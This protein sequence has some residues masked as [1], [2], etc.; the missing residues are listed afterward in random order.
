MRSRRTRIREN[1][2]GSLVSVSTS[3]FEVCPTCRRPTLG[4]DCYQNS[5]RRLHP[6]LGLF[7][8]EQ[9]LS[10]IRRSGI[11]LSVTTTSTSSVRRCLRICYAIVP[12]SGSRCDDQTWTMGRRPSH[13]PLP[14]VYMERSRLVS[15]IHCLRTQ[16]CNRR[17]EVF[18]PTRP[19]NECRD[20]GVLGD[21]EYEM[22]HSPR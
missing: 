5:S 16:T 21:D 22:N 18:R 13:Q 6:I 15:W 12:T 19:K 3:V 14:S 2:S 17:P 20:M 7:R 8:S 1:V 9:H 10:T 4:V 11:Y